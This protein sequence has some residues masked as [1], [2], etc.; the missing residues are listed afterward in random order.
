MAVKIFCN[1][2]QEFIRDAKQHELS[3]LKGTEI[4][5]S[6]ETRIKGLFDE[7]DRVAKKSV[8]K[9]QNVAGQARAELEEA[10]RRVIK[11][12]E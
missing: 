12:G 8:V 2:C 11:E 6:C 7:V 9:I 5:V 4:C 10:M 1:A 3:D